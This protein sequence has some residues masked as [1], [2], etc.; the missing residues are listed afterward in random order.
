[1]QAECLY[2]F[3]SLAKELQNL[4]ILAD[5]TSKRTAELQKRS[6]FLHTTHDLSNPQKWLMSD[7]KNY[8]RVMTELQ[9]DIKALK[10]QRTI[11]RRSLHEVGSHMLKAG[12]KKEEIVRFN[13]AKT[14][15]EFAKMLKVRTLGPE[16]LETQTQLRRDIRAI[17]DRIQK[18]EDHLQASKKRISEFRTGKP[19][20][21][22]P[23]LDTIA[24]TFRNIDI[25]IKHQ[26][27]DVN[28]LRTRLSKLNIS[29]STR[30]GDKSKRSFAAPK[31]SSSSA[32]TSKHPSNVT[33]NVAITTAAAL[34]AER[35]A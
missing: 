26:S 22:A 4:T 14:D 30:G 5:M 1:M 23:S 28:T 25:A 9:A 29:D 8:G 19:A 11:L 12:T 27:E 17:R 16:Y 6:G 2:L 10:D 32:T 20:L 24:R 3:S 33:P 18:L 13:R 21:R 15:T 31:D 34:N 35:S 7:I